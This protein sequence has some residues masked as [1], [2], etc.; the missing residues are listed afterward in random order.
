MRGAAARRRDGTPIA[1]APRMWNRRQVLKAFSA[2]LEELRDGIV[3]EKIRPVHVADRACE[4]FG[5][6]LKAGGK[7]PSVWT[8]RAYVMGRK[9][10]SRLVGL[11]AGHGVRKSARMDPVD[12]LAAF[13]R[14]LRDCRDEIDAGRIRP[15]AIALHAHRIFCESVGVLEKKP[16]WTSFLQLV[17]GRNARTEIVR[18]L[19]E[20]RVK[21][22]RHVR[23]DRERLVLSFR[24]A[25]ERLGTRIEKGKAKAIQVAN[26]AHE[27]YVAGLAAD[28]PKPSR[29]TFH[30]LVYGKT[31]D[32]GI[33]RLLQENILKS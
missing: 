10:D 9:A 26:R 18:L 23:L 8:F 1:L 6:R 22:G 5:G 4:I 33:V 20:R 31:A 30:H 19:S 11:L 12:V 21:R 27:F 7:R 14:A 32:Q 15:R 13:H 25:V 29:R 17:S 24:R 3:L 2:A 28:Q 16:A